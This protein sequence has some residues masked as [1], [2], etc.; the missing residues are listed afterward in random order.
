MIN[1]IGFYNFYI[2]KYP[3]DIKLFKLWEEYLL[4]NNVDIL[5]NSSISNIDK[6]YIIVNDTQIYS[7]KFIF[8]C[9]PSAICNILKKSNYPY[10]FGDIYNWT[11]LT[12]YNKYI[13]F[14]FHYNQNINLPRY[15]AGEVTS[16]TEYG[17]IYII[18]SDYMKFND[19]R[20]KTVISITLSTPPQDTKN[21]INETYTQLKNIFNDLPYPH[22]IV[23]GK[24]ISDSFASTKF[25]YMNYKSQILD[26][27]YTCGHHIGHSNF[28]Y[29]TLESAVI[30]ALYLS[31]EL[32]NKD[33][34]IHEPIKL[35]NIIKIV[36]IFIIIII[37]II[38][39]K[40]L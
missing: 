8:A 2:P 38:I 36:I 3:N 39:K 18:M 13:S 10:L 28:E 17:I 4:N 5:L 11:T 31:S 32:T 15:W 30:N 24:T 27:Y 12:N 26:N 29:N 34:I 35:L 40:I 21:I 33:I 37:I 7:N 9:P 19:D 1:L 20:S 14:T 23:F 6:N 16:K 22:N 25:G